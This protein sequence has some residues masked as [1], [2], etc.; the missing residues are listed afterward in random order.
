MTWYQDDD[1]DGYGTDTSTFACPAPAGNWVLESGDCDDTREE[2]HPG[3]QKFFGVPYQKADAT[4]SFDYDCSAKEEP[5]PTLAI[6]PEGCGL[7]GTLGCGMDSGYA[8]NNRA[9]PGINEWCGSTVVRGC[10]AKPVGC[11]IVERVD[12]PPFTCR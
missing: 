7:L 10:K 5:N 6:A 12:Q 11:E 4:D 1:G 9:G 2:V 3:Q 8:E